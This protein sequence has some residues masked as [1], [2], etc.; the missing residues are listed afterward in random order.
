MIGG[1]GGITVWTGNAFTCTSREI[2]LFTVTMD[3]Q[4]VHTENV[5]TYKERV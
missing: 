1:Q 2:S 4:M 3:L 5:V